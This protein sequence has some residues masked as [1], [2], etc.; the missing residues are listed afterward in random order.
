MNAEAQRFP[1]RD[2]EK[3]P[4]RERRRHCRE[5]AQ[6]AQRG[7]GT[8]EERN[9]RPRD[10]GTTDH[11]T[12]GLGGKDRGQRSEVRFGIFS[13]F[14]SC[15]LRLFA[16]TPFFAAINYQQSAINHFSA[17]VPRSRLPFD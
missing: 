1:R 2:A 10:H 12:R 4:T 15:L 8:T 16:A 3:A 17:S 11:G 13:C 9:M 7:D 5:K 14:F 6:E